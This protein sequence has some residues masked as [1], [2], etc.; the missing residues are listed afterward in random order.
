M[1]QWLI[2]EWVR[3]HLEIVMLLDAQVDTRCRVGFEEASLELGRHPHRGGVGGA[4]DW[5]ERGCK[6]TV[7]GKSGA[8][9]Q[10]LQKGGNGR[11]GCLSELF[12][13]PLLE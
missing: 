10:G 11:L 8:R 2:G 6:E 7:G 3:V 9:E 5:A 12:V 4:G 1:E 13:N